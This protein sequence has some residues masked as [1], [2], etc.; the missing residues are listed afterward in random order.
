MRCAL[1]ARFG[2]KQ[3]ILAVHR[4][5]IHADAI[6]RQAVRA[7]NRHPRS[8]AACVPE[9]AFL[10]VDALGLFRG[11]IEEQRI[12][13]VD[14]RDETA[15][16]AEVTAGLRAVLAEVVAPVPAFVGTSTMQ[17]LPSRRLRQ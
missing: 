17:S 3:L 4:A 11:D 8:P 1:H 13:L 10:R 16:F 14:A 15:P 9:Q 7:C 6:V 2:T 12:E 5:R